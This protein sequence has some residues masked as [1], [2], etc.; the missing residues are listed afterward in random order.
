MRY[1]VGVPSLT[2]SMWA[3]GKIKLVLYQSITQPTRFQMGRRVSVLDLVRI[4][5][6]DRL[7]AL[8]GNSVRALLSFKFGLHDSHEITRPRAKWCYN[9][10]MKG[11]V[12]EYYALV[13]GLQPFAQ[14]RAQ[15]EHRS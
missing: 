14:V 10:R 13:I 7:L 11:A 2:R 3:K 5:F 9:E 15:I 4:T 1:F 12:V 8:L 6:P